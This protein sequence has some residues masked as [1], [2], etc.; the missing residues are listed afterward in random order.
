[1]AI[2]PINVGHAAGSGGI[3]PAGSGRDRGSEKESVREISRTPYADRVEI[4]EQGRALAAR[5]QMLRA[6]GGETLDAARIA[7][8]RERIRRG[9]Y[10][11]P[12]VL[13]AVARRLLELGEIDLP[14]DR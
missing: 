5:E 13:T 12:E 10:D 3:R 6:E 11:R 14:V 1:M 4:S 2:D 8:L 9:D 7:E